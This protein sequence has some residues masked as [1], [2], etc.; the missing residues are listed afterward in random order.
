MS[1]RSRLGKQVEREEVTDPG[2]PIVLS[3]QRALRVLDCIADEPF[4]IGPREI[5]RRLEFHPGTTQKIL[6]TLRTQGYVTAHGDTSK[7]RLGPAVSRLA[8]RA[9]AHFDL[10]ATAAPVLQNL[11]LRTGETALVGVRRGDV[12]T[13]VAKVASSQA[14]RMDIAINEPRPL[15]ATATGK[16]L[17]AFDDDLALERLRVLSE[18]GNFLAPT[19]NSVTDPAEL[20]GQ[21]QAVRREGVAYDLREYVADGVCIAAPVFGPDGKIVAGITLSGPGGRMEPRLKEYRR[22]LVAA[23]EALQKALGG[24]TPPRD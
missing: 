5:A 13:Y 14:V 7:Y 8:S 16:V 9:A 19:P 2:E 24:N 21:L 6:N 23:A 10:A 1:R 4:G 3:V 17:L 18:Q 15:N 20:L 11:A 22:E 12:C